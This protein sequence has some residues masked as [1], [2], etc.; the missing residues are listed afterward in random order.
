MFKLNPQQ[1][2]AVRYIDGPL[3]V[4]AGA[5]SGKTRVITEKIVYLIRD[6][7]IKASHIAAVT[8]TNKAAQEMKV[9]VNQSIGSKE[10]RGLQIATFH[11]LG[12]TIIRQAVAEL[13]LKTG[14]SIFDEQD[15]KSLLRELMQQHYGSNNDEIIEQ[16]LRYIS[17]WKNAMLWP[18]HVLVD[19]SDKIKQQAVMLYK[20]YNRCLRAYNAVDF[21]DLILLPVWLF[22]N[23]TIWLERWQHKIH[24]LLV[25]EYQDTNAVQYELIKLLTGVRAAFTVVGDDDQSIYTWRGARPENLIQLQKDYPKLKLIKLEQNYRSCGR[26]LKAA[27]QLIANNPHVFSE[28]KLWSALGYGDP[29]QIIGTKDDEHEA[30][31][32]VGELLSHK[33][34]CRAQFRDYAILYRGNHQ[35]RVFEKVL[36]NYEVPYK[37]SGGTSFFAKIEIRDIMA[38]LRMLFNSD[39]DNAFLRIINTPRRGIGSAT[40][41]KLG[42]YAKQRNISLFASCFEIGLAQLLDEGVYTKLQQFCTWLKHIAEKCEHAEPLVVIQETLQQMGYEEWVF[43]NCNDPKAAQRRMDNVQLLL[44][45]IQRMLASDD[46]HEAVSIKE[47]VTKLTLLDRLEQQED[48]TLDQVQLMTLHA[49]KGLE[50]PNVFLVGMEEELLPHRTSIEADQIEEERR[51]AYVGLTRAKSSLI[52]TFA[53]QRKS[54]G[55]KIERQPSRFLQE[56]P[57]DDVIWHGIETNPHPEQKLQRGKAHLA[58]LKDMLQNG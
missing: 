55:E 11:T 48:D 4:L 37:L 14:F 20:E 56:L 5:G 7:G 36:R 12:V 45:W 32:V 34:K 8:F 31:R 18:E 1:Q 21:D 22:R 27:N 13:N 6:C 10:A 52:I 16:T 57:Q 46:I 39:D 47:V 33:F 17:E 58:L 43:E 2:S 3:L 29:I 50:F 42:Q 28:K 51:L 15:C 35:A 26:I 30:E 40:L 44:K 54:Y 24:Y 19:G 23:N 25:D 9:R 53:K 38:Y 41:E 49:A